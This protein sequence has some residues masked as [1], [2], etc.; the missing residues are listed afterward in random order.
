MKK[1]IIGGLAV[2]AVGVAAMVYAQV[3]VKVDV[4]CDDVDTILKIVQGEYK[5]VPVLVAGNKNSQ[6]VFLGNKNT[7]T[8][9]VMQMSK[10]TACVLSAGNNYTVI[11][12]NTKL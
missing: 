3:T 5:E 9:T 4:I 12:S 1:L 11:E 6:L 2:A 8:W 7:G 10:N